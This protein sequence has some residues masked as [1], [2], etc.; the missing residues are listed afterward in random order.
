MNTLKYLFLLF[1]LLLSPALA[2]ENEWLDN[3]DIYLHTVD[4]GTMVYD[5]FGHT[6]VRV[7]NR[8]NGDDLV[9][10]WGIFDFR[11]PVEFSLKFYRGILIYN[12]GVYDFE[13]AKKYY[14]F[15]KRTVWED[16]LNL[17]REQKFILLNRFHQNYLP[18]N[19]Q[20]QYHYFFNNCSTI[21]RD[22]FN[23]A[24]GGILEKKL[25]T[26]ILPKSFRHT[27]Q[28][29]YSTNPEI[30][31]SLDLLMNGNID[32]QM[33]AWQEMFLPLKLRDHLKNFS[34]SQPVF[35]DS[36]ILYE[37]RSP[38]PSLLNGYHYFAIFSLLC[39]LLIF[40][41]SKG[42]W[43]I[44]GK[45]AWGLTSLP[46]LLIG[47][48]G[49]TMLLNWIFS[50]HIDLHHNIN[51]LLLLPTD[52]ILLYPILKFFRNKPLDKS[53]K[54]FKNYLKIHTISLAAYLLLG[55]IGITGQNIFYPLIYILPV[56]ALFLWQ[57][58]QKLTP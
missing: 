2:A 56:Y 23:E 50:G 6:A 45:L 8:N 3:I 21:V 13:S 7:N 16:K 48:F 31:I 27:V 38:A 26:E 14:E 53:V 18:E 33:T 5:N 55:I 58:D 54:F 12:L 28:E 4:H 1:T 39:S 46:L 15:E 52:L 37:F 20:Y 36:K 51:L 40:L 34:S 30:F 22:H 19:R 35:S 44:P 10:N 29:G 11:D 25:T 57:I 17:T 42:K 47:I 24:L 49:L 9:Y 43:K 41:N 32:K